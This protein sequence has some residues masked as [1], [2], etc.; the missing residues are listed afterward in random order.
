[1]LILHRF[2]GMAKENA[3]IISFFLHILFYIVSDDAQ[4]KLQQC[5]A[6]EFLIYSV[7]TP[8][9]RHT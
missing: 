7:A 2:L 1:M 8:S 4:M 5:I 9:Y 3:L 6:A